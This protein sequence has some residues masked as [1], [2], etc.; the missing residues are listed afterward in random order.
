MKEHLKYVLK[1][2]NSLEGFID[3][4]RAAGAGDDEGKAKV[5]S[6]LLMH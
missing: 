5:S 2:K 4:I 3:K 6:C 1:A